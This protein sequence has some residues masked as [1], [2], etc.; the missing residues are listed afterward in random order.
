[1]RSKEP[2]APAVVAIAQFDASASVSPEVESIVRSVDILPL[3]SV[4]LIVDSTATVAITDTTANRIV[5][6]AVTDESKDDASTP[7][8]SSDST[9]TTGTT[10]NSGISF[11][12]YNI[13]AWR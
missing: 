9:T 11:C 5:T 6:A 12:Q 13:D 3:S 1:M 4:N 7:L 8:I 10:P 2:R